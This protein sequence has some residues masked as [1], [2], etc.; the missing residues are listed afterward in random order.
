MLWEGRHAA[1]IVIDNAYFYALF[2]LL[3]QNIMDR[4]PHNTILND[5]VFH[6]NETLRFFQGFQ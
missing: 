3:H 1:E 2:Y 4:F 5:E 6:E